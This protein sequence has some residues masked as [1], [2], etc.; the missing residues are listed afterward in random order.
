M[1]NPRKRQIGSRLGR[2]CFLPP[3]NYRAERRHFQD[4]RKT[5][6][7]D[8]YQCPIATPWYI[9]SVTS[10]YHWRNVV[11]SSRFCVHRPSLKL[12]SKGLPL[13]YF[14]RCT[15]FFV[16]PLSTLFSQDCLRSGQFAK[17]FLFS[18]VSSPSRSVPSVP[19]VRR[20]ARICALD[21]R[22]STRLVC[23]KP[24]E[25]PSCVWGETCGCRWKLKSWF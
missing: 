23:A 8:F 20:S 4:R 6:R 19:C 18:R 2:G 10:M 22:L 24:S 1:I 5:Y 17:Y 15:E 9:W 13:Q 12:S 3:L 11:H 21:A 7:I 25:C 16:C 14:F